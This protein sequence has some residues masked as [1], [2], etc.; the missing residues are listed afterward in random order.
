MRNVPTLPRTG[1]HGEIKTASLLKRRPN[2]CPERGELWQ[3]GDTGSTD[4]GDPW[5]PQ[6]PETGIPT[7]ET[8]ELLCHQTGDPREGESLG[9]PGPPVAQ[10]GGSPQRRSQRGETRDS[11][12]A[13]IVLPGMDWG[14]LLPLAWRQNPSSPCPSSP[15]PSSPRQGAEDGDQEDKSPWQNLVEEAVLSSST[16]QESNGEEEPQRSHRKRGSKPSPGCSKEERPTLCQ[17]GSQRSSWSL[18]LVVYEQLPDGEKLYGSSL[19]QHH[20]GE[21]PYEC[22]ECRKSFI[23]SSSLICH[24]MIHSGEQPY[25]CLECG[26]SFNNSSVL[27]RHRHIHSGERPLEC[28]ECGKNFSTSSCLICHLAIHIR[29]TPVPL[30]APG[31]NVRWD[32]RT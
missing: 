7:G 2:E 31:N 14:D 5:V 21:W 27:I 18:E 24:Q 25:T 20:T 23:Q 10:R 1:R 26:K 30:L 6:S 13:G 17:D 3:P 15:C 12:T 19:T 11:P 28:Q 4:K 32:Q 9:S 16:V 22:V 29:K 8:L